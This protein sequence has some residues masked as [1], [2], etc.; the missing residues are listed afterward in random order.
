MATA[1]GRQWLAQA[2]DV[3]RELKRKGR[4]PDVQISRFLDWLEQNLPG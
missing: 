3:L 4:L 1:E 2:R